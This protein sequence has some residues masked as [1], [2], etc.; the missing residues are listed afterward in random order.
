MY[1]HTYI[2]NMSELFCSKCHNVFA[3]KRNLNYHLTHSVCQKHNKQCLKCDK[4]FSNKE[5]LYYHQKNNVCQQTNTPKKLLKLKTSVDL[6]TIS[7]ES[8]YEE[9][10]RLR[11]QIESLEKNPRTNN[12]TVN[13][14]VPPAFL[15]LDTCQHILQFLPNLLHDALSKHPAECISY[16]IKETNCNPELPIYNSVKIS[17]KKDPFVQISNGDKY[18]YASK[19]KTIDQL[20]ENKRHILQEYIDQN[21]DNYGEKILKNYQRFVDALDDEREEKRELEC[22]VI[23][24]LLNISDVIGSDEWSRKLLND[25]KKWD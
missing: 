25:L 13:I 22:D 11:G 17:N 6:S 14:V 24:M 8:L 9:N 12:N 4:I 23:C 15:K 10:L 1:I 21:G 3:N 7:K 16:L 18:V 5:K 19:Q 2:T 20:I